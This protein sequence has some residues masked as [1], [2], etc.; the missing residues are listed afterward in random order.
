MRHSFLSCALAVAFAVGV[1]GTAE[2][3][4]AIIVHDFQGGADGAHPFGGM[5]QDASGD[6]YGTTGAG[7]GGPCGGG[8]GTLFKIGRHGSHTVVY[9]FTGGADGYAPDADLVGDANG[10]I[11]GTTAQGNSGDGSIFL[12][13]PKG[14]LQVLHSFASGEGSP[15]GRLWV[16][17]NGDI[18]GTT[19]SGGA[20]TD[21]TIFKLSA[22][23]LSTLYTFRGEEDGRWPHGVVMD[24]GGTLFGATQNGADPSCNCGAV[25]ALS[26]DGAF[27]V[28]HTFLGR[29]DGGQPVGGL[30][31]TAAGIVGTAYYGGDRQGSG[32]IFRIAADGSFSVLHTFTRRSDGAHPAA[33]LTADSSGDLYGTAQMGGGCRA[34]DLGCGTAFRLAA[35]GTFTVLH[36]FEDGSDGRSPTA[37][38]ILSG[39]S[40][41]GT[42]AW[43]GTACTNGCG[44]VFRIANNN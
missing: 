21:G 39:A 22:G 35:D 4:R 33:V 9:D 1:A 31:L 27:S 44:V 38:L 16:A 30:T 41:Y 19:I 26:P 32:V 25:F 15:S 5:V 10:N 20:A 40:V 14:P 7:G 18:Y 28:L 36:K 11:Y 37:P 43:G 17:A 6:F 12:Q 29:K 8:C 34:L 23:T 3:G 2:A 24:G 13:P 42:A